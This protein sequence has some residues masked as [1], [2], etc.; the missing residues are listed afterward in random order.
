VVATAND[1]SILPPE[2]L[3]KGRFDEIFFVDLPNAREREEICT[4]HLLL[5]K[6]DPKKLHLEKVV[7]ATEGLS[8]AETE[9]VVIASLYRTLYL[10]RVLDTDLLVEEIQAT[11]PLSV[12]RKEDILNL[13]ESAR[14]RFLPLS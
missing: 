10:K 5:R 4:I 14:G 7:Y 2:L 11:I 9:Q 6:K 12:S 3:R 13:R 8:G 1:L